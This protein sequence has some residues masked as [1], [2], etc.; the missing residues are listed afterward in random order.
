M[1]VV[2]QIDVTIARN[3]REDEA[4]V[5]AFRQRL[6]NDYPAIKTLL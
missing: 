6:L 3:E 1:Q 4:K 2:S 5:E